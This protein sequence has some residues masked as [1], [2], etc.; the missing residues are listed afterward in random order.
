MGL[1]IVFV[2]V[3]IA[4]GTRSDTIFVFKTLTTEV[5]GWNNPGISWGLGLLSMTFSVTGADS[6][7]HM[8]KYRMTTRF[9]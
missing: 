1:F 5:S 3:L 7:I 6:V 2:A 9:S 8:C 4:K